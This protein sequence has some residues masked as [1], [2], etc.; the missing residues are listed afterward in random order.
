MKEAHMVDDPLG[1]GKIEVLRNSDL[2]PG[3]TPRRGKVRDVYDLGKEMLI[4]TTDRISAYDVVFP[5]LIPHKGES[6][7]K[8]AEFWFNKTQDVIP[9]H[10]ISL[11]DRRT[12]RVKKAE[13]VDIEFVCRAYLYGSAWRAYRD[14]ARTVSGVELPNGLV[15]AERLPDVIL[16]PT[17]KAEEGHDKEISGREAIIQGLVTRDEWRELEE[18]TLKLF[19]AY[20]SHAKSRGFIIPDFK[21][22]FG[23]LEGELIQIDEPPSHD[24]A[25]FWAERFYEPGK[26]QEAHC[27]DK[28]F[29]RA[30][31]RE[32]GYMGDGLIP[33]IPAQIVRQVS[34]R[35]VAS[36]QVLSGNRSL[37]EY[38]LKT[39]DGVM[40]ELES[41]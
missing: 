39:V 31:L 18:A 30:Y 25:R 12:M 32:V 3:K 37:S 1:P 34:M 4:V 20:Q 36:Y 29:L 38:D 16:T 41:R 22:E 8:L 13:R 28:E 5:T 9:N 40:A 23:R 14:G 33:D 2:I 26:P 19:A 21:L 27:L 11:E 24:S 7:N 17:T 6:I 15:M 35:C 10:F